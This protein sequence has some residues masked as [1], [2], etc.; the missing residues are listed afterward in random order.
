MS[1]CPLTDQDCAC[2]KTITITE[3]NQNDKIIF[4]LC[5]RCIDYYINSDSTVS[6]LKAIQ[7]QINNKIRQLKG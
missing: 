5:E 3:V 4:K 2:L 1:K 6:E 7:K